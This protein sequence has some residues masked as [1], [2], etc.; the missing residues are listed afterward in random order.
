MAERI[1]R[2]DL[3]DLVWSEPLVTLAARFKISDVALRKTCQKAAIPTPERGYWAR[4]DAGQ[5]C[6]VPSL[7]ERPPAMGDEVLVAGG[8]YAWQRQWSREELLGPLPPPPTFDTPLEAVRAQIARSIGEV[9]V[10]REVRVWHPAIQ[11]LLR[12]DEARREN[13]KKF[14]YSWDSPLFDSPAARLRLRLL[15][16][17]FV[18]VGRCNGAARPDKDAKSAVLSFYRQHVNI[19]LGTSV[20]L[21][22]RSA[23]RSTPKEGGSWLAIR[24]S[25]GSTKDLKTW[26][27]AG[28]TKLE[29]QLTKIAIEIVLLAEA[30]YRGGVESEYAWRVKR[31][32]DLEEEDRKRTL[33]AER[34]EAERKKK[35]EQARIDRLLR[36]AAAFE[37]ASVIRRFVEGIRNQAGA[38]L[39]ASAEELDR[40]SSWA[41]AQADR[42][43]PAVGGKFL[44]SMTGE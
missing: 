17:L 36:D 30:R 13:Q 21:E 4:K 19:A 44:T 3:Y 28:G 41:L 14:S 34:A 15:N 37:Q 24:E 26:R 18:A 11:R 16:A 6:P 10:P 5:K 20:H 39:A 7:P 9:K 31:K 35:L 12:E 22:K 40:W 1:S 42:V 29:S 8:Q 33:E 2:K 32:A 23:S 27:D 25:W 43:D 38:A